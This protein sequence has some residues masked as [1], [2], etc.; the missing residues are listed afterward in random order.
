MKLCWELGLKMV[1]VVT[2][3]VA[4]VFMKTGLDVDVEVASMIGLASE[5]L[6]MT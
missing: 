5:L 6:A 2:E 4:K 3:A 1:L